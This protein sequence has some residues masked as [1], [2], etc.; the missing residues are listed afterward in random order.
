MSIVT[1]RCAPGKMVGLVRFE[2]M[3]LKQ[4][5]AHVGL[6]PLAEISEVPE[7]QPGLDAPFE[8]IRSVSVGGTAAADDGAS[9]TREKDA[10]TALRC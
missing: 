1:R 2:L 6:A 10:S 3:T 8:C 5:L 9:V 4:H 7:V